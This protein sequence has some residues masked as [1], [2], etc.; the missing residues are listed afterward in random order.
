MTDPRNDDRI[1]LDD[2]A[3]AAWMEQVDDACAGLAGISVLD[4]T[5]QPFRDWHDE[6]LTPEDAAILT[7]EANGW[8]DY[9]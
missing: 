3:F 9:R 8:E 4:L 6:G 7:L 5:D 2:C 1:P